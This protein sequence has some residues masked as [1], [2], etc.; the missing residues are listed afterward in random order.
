[1]YDFVFFFVPG[2]L[3]VAVRRE[4]GYKYFSTMQFPENVRS[5]NN[6]RNHTWNKIT[7]NLVFY[8]KK[9]MD[10]TNVSAIFFNDFFFKKRNN[11]YTLQ[12]K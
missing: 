10:K 4:E 2:F 12:K 7:E 9:Q 8:H 3:Y 6:L 5:Y 11:V 1:M